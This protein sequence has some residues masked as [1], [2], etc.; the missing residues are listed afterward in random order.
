[1]GREDS[2]AS[3]APPWIEAAH[4]WSKSDASSSGDS[5]DSTG[6]CARHA[7][8]KHRRVALDM[9]RDFCTNATS[10]DAAAPRVEMRSRTLRW[11]SSA[12]L[13]ASI[14][15][16][17]SCETL[18]SLPGAVKINVTLDPTAASVAS[19][20]VGAV[21]SGEPV[22][23]DLPVRDGAGDEGAERGRLDVMSVRRSRGGG[24]RS[25]RGASDPDTARSASTATSKSGTIDSLQ[26][27]ARRVLALGASLPLDGDGPVQS[28]TAPM[29]LGF[30]SDKIPESWGFLDRF[31][32]SLQADGLS[33]GRVKCVAVH[34]RDG[35]ASPQ[36]PPLPMHS[37]CRVVWDNGGDLVRCIDDARVGRVYVLDPEGRLLTA[38]SS[39]V[40]AYRRLAS[41]SSNNTPTVE[42]LPDPH[43]RLI[44]E[45][46]VWG[47]DRTSTSLRSGTSAL[48]LSRIGLEL[49][50][51][52]STRTTPNRV[53]A[54]SYGVDNLESNFH[55]LPSVGLER[56]EHEIRDGAQSI[57]LRYTSDS[58]ESVS[59]SVSS[60]CPSGI[61]CGTLSVRGGR[62]VP[63][64][65]LYTERAATP[66]P[67][68]RTS[69]HMPL[70]LSQ[71][72]FELEDALA[73]CSGAR[74]GEISES[75]CLDVA[76]YL[77]RAARRPVDGAALSLPKAM[78]TRAPDLQG[79]EGAMLG[80]VMSDVAYSIVIV[81]GRDDELQRH[82]SD[83]SMLLAATSARPGLVFVDSSLESTAKVKSRVFR[84]PDHAARRGLLRSLGAE[85]GVPAVAM[86]CIVDSHGTVLYQADSVLE[87]T[88]VHHMLRIAAAH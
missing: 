35:T 45:L 25:Q 84:S 50:S 57:E 55:P 63:I 41:Y 20:G 51:D 83:V 71:S 9:R 13:V 58:G 79:S 54:Y 74:V 43:G 39:T 18:G 49:Y 38:T 31:F 32:G 29:L 72:R 62:P 34:I 64:A 14:A 4:S 28:D 70:R 23:P 22:T 75:I 5:S 2:G 44:A 33:P 12:A 46:L 73:F 37:K 36:A 66:T 85:D 53:A 40:A 69:R 77:S 42:L 76:S 3:A 10:M 1:M 15:L 47:D 19:S 81:G 6:A 68:V 60:I 21:R 17:F 80:V 7:D 27:P 26:A 11:L 86:S 67:F 8:L 30:Y 16:L 87:P 48:G 56:F 61:G 65:V 82:E 52:D 24:E 88:F 59:I 78:R